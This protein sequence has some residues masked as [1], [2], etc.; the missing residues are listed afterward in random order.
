MTSYAIRDYQV[1]DEQGVMTLLR[2]TLGEGGSFARTV[3][4]WRWKHFQNPFGHSQLLL[5]ANE[6]VLGLR[7]FMRWGFVTPAGR[8]RAVRA[9]D[10]S[11]H[12]DYRR[13]GIFSKLTQQSVEQA[14]A[15]GV[16]LIF[17]T[18][19]PQSMAGYLKLGWHLV[20]RPRLLIRPLNPLR[21]IPALLLRPKRRLTAE[22]AQRFFRSSPTP[23]EALLD[24]ADRMEQIL[25]FDSNIEAKGIRTDRSLGFLQWRYAAAPSPRYYALWTGEKPVTGAVIVR[26]NIRNGLREIMLCEFLIGY[27]AGPHARELIGQLI[28]AVR[29]DYLVASA[30]PG[31]Y[32]WGTLTRAGF[33]A[34]PARFGPNFTVHP[35][36]WP[37]GELDPARIEHWR[38]SLGDL[39]IF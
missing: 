3:D 24:H 35:L 30:S 39:E 25:T 36:N 34:L 31:T 16:N 33:I 23:V 38:L 15:D 32:H 6:Q 14:R 13:V 22:A 26:P 37:A 21:M 28:K 11:T 4:F 2:T 27:G 19:N 20:G 8:L 10:T 29:A 9:V 5:A 1:D 18:P 17:N 7:A 12:P